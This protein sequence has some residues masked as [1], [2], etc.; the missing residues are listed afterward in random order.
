MAD[1]LMSA[2]SGG[3]IDTR[4]LWRR[5]VSGLR[6]PNALLLAAGLI[7]PNLLSLVSLTSLVD[8]GLPPRPGAIVL[9]ATLAILARRIPFA[10]SA[11][12]FVGL[13]CF[14]L[15]RTLSL[16]FGLAPGEIIA[17]LDQAR[18]I[19]FFASPLYASLIGAVAMTTLATLACLKQRDVLVRAN[20]SL[21]LVAA[22]CFATVDYV[23]NVSPHYQFGSMFGR[24]QPVQ[25][26][27]EISGFNAAAGAHGNNVVVVIVESLGY[28]IDP[29]ARRRIAAPLYDSALT[30][31]Y[32]VTEGHTVYYG[33]TT[34]G[35]M[36]E[37]CNTRVFY[38]EFVQKYGYSCL[39]DLL[40]RRGYT[41]IAVHAFSGGMFEREQWYPK[42]G[43]D[44]ELFGN[45]LIKT[46]HRICGS[47][48]RGACD[49]DLAPAIAAASRQAARGGKPRF[50]YW[51]TLNTHIPV[52]PGEARTDFRC[53]MD[54]SGFGRPTVCR[55]AE[56]WHDVFRSVAAIARDPAVG[57]ADILIVGDH[58]PPL[59]SK[60]GRAQFAPGQ[61]AWYRLQPRSNT[62]VPTRQASGASTVT[63]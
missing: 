32:N 10:L 20:A 6:S 45:D 5:C 22:F 18:R 12:L 63:P 17:A 49:A 3:S 48:F 44:R 1:E 21:L 51:L 35:E 50:I 52:A 37:L 14:D 43:F 55:M 2:A 16:M 11:I 4:A 62:A 58:A 29:D 9:Y 39:P 19:H 31:D 54:G 34:S 57:P 40:D 42:V 28:L 7:L 13:L 15:V 46:T 53:G 36:R 60:R 23:S 61:V 24:G 30:K 25:S 47:A 41:S 38:S 27:A 26:A 59:W 8:I 56:L 33:S